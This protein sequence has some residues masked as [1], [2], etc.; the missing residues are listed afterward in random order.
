LLVD[1][2]SES[3]NSC[4]SIVVMAVLF[5]IIA[6]NEKEFGPLGERHKNTQEKDS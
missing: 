4:C 2:L 1:Q 6:K 5:V 3:I